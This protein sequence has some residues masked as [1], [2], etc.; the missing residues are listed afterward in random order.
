MEKKPQAANTGKSRWFA[1]E[2]ITR[3]FLRGLC[4]ARAIVQKGTD[5]K[6]KKSK[7]KT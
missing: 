2:G 6:K 7:K 5:Q 1:V 4:E 3:R